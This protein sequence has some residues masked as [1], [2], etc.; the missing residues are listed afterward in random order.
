MIFFSLVNGKEFKMYLRHNNWCSL[1][2][3]VTLTARN[4]RWWDSYSKH[5]FKN[6]LDL[7]HQ[8]LIAGTLRNAMTR[9]TD[10][11]GRSLSLQL[12]ELLLGLSLEIF[13]V[14]L[15][16]IQWRHNDGRMYATWK[17]EGWTAMT[18]HFG[19]HELNINCLFLQYVLSIVWQQ[20]VQKYLIIY[21]GI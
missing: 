6:F 2:R 14:F 4:F 5:G 11:S 10:L 20:S 9:D 16:D 19:A 1:P 18:S 21:I 17:V 12:K 15:Q 7:G 3:I 8:S 13:K